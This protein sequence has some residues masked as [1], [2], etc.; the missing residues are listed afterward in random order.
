ME[1]SPTREANSGST[2]PEILLVIW[3][4]KVY[5]CVHNFPPLVPFLSVMNP[6]HN[7]TVL[8]IHSNIILLSM[9]R[10]SKLSLTFTFSNRNYLYAFLFSLLRATCSA[11]LIPLALITLTINTEKHK[12]RNCTLWSSLPSHFT[13]SEHP[14]HCLVLKLSA[15]SFLSYTDQFSNPY[16]TTCKWCRCRKHIKCGSFGGG[17][18]KKIKFVVLCTFWVKYSSFSWGSFRLPELLSSAAMGHASCFVFV[19]VLVQQQ[20]IQKT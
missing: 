3:N 18:N 10:S 13:F 2:G 16:K 6:I 19:S 14:L 4:S 20:T 9:P 15:C 7:F 12:L 5:Y 11:H 1:Q 8:K 17:G